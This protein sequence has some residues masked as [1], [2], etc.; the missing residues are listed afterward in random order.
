ML[1]VCAAAQ[2]GEPTSIVEKTKDWYGKRK[3]K[4]R[5]A[6]GVTLAVGLAVVAHLHERADA[7]RYDAEDIRDSESFSDPVKS[8]P[9]C[10]GEGRRVHGEPILVASCIDTARLARIRGRPVVGMACLGAGGT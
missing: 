3:P 1:P 8:Q 9:E 4:I 2:D 10:L 7:E 5:V 6:L